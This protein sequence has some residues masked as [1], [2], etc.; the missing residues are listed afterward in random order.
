MLDHLAAR[1]ADGVVEPKT[2]V[3]PDGQTVL[4][5]PQSGRVMISSFLG[6]VIRIDA[7]Q[8]IG[9]F[10]RHTDTVF[11]HQIGELST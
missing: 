5:A 1:R 4:A 7:F 9:G 3:V 11:D 8:L 6:E 2:P 10:C